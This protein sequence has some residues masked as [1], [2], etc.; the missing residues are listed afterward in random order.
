MRP[1]FLTR[2]WSNWLTLLGSVTAALA[3]L[4]TVVVVAV[5]GSDNPYASGAILLV[6]PSMLFLGVV[7]VPLG[8]WL[9]R[10]RH[11]RGAPEGPVAAAFD[12]A[13]AD[14]RARWQMLFV[15]VSTVCIVIL[16]SLGGSTALHHMD[17]PKFCG[18]ACH[19]PMQPEWEAYACSPHSEVACVGCHVGPGAG[20]EAKAK[21]N[22]LHQGWTMLRGTYDKPIPAPSVNAAATCEKCHAR[23]RFVGDRLRA[24]PK[25]KRDQASTPAWTVLA[26]HVGGK[27]PKSGKY[28]GIHAHVAP[29]RVIR[30][31][32]LDGG[33]DRIGRI[34]VVDGGR[35]T[36]EYLPPGALQAG[37]PVR[38]MACADCHN[39]PAHRFDGT[40]RQAVD[41]AIADG[42][43][44]RATPW[45][46]QVATDV[47]ARARPARDDAEK[48]FAGALKAGYAAH[49]E[50]TP[51]D[52]AIAAA[53]H[54]LAELYRRNVYPEMNLGFGTYPDLVGHY[55]D[56][57]QP[58]GCFR[59]HDKGHAATVGG[60]RKVLGQ[61][62]DSCHETLVADED[63][64]K[65]DDTLKPLL[66]AGR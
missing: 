39:R 9:Q 26:L 14:K 3:A 6:L 24:Y 32:A 27:N 42:K 47:L 58:T 49:P 66:N 44:D 56:G 31:Q 57:D 59:C 35:V 41:R 2:L 64:A 5:G 63:P 18:T 30:Y 23:E 10:R 15:L 33:R 54:A 17:S 12:K 11:R 20:A 8:L 60:E 7:L 43:L 61:D 19:T 34:T 36:A 22:G 65:L 28:E 62:C 1:A 53:A 55:S 50:A 37:G 51:S 25:Y 38:E 29:G 13:F 40:A 52:Q 4:A 16:L 45:I 48:Y 21:W 46:A